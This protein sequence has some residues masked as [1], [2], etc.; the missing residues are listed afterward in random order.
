MSIRDQEQ[1]QRKAE[2]R[3]DAVMRQSQKEVKA[4]IRERQEEAMKK[5]EED[6]RRIEAGDVQPRQQ[7]G[8]RADSMESMSSL[9]SMES[10]GSIKSMESI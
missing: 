2:R 4:G 1:R 5:S 6:I 7:P 9:E 10:I 3:M 8:I